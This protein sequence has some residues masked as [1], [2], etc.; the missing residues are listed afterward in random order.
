MDIIAFAKSDLG[1]A[2]AWMATVLSLLLTIWAMWTKQ[3]LKVENINLKHEID[4]KKINQVGKNNA[5]VEKNKG[6]I[7]F[8]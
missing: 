8:N 4:N 3:A 6:G 5:Y 1:V 2:I 7:H